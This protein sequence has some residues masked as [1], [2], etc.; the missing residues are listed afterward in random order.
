MPASVAS[1][2]AQ[3]CELPQAWRGQ[4][5][6]RI[7]DT[8]FVQGLDFF[9]TWQSWQ[10]DPQ[11][12]PMLHYVAFSRV[13][14]ALDSLQRTSQDHPALKPLVDELAPQWFGLLPGF[15]RLT[16]DSGRVLLTLCVGDTT[17]LLRQQHFQADAIF[18]RPKANAPAD[19]DLWAIKALARLCRRGTALAVAQGDSVLQAHLTQCGFEI[20]DTPPDTAESP[21]R[22]TFNP[23]WTLKTSRQTIPQAS[24]AGSCIVIGSGLAGASVAA[25]L[26]R[27]GWQVQVLDQAAT[28]AAGASGLPVGLVVPHVSTDDCTLSRLSRSGVRLMRQQA[29]SLLTEGADWQACGTLE[30]RLDGTSGLP[31]H[32]PPE[33]EDWSRAVTPA[34][35]GTL[36]AAAVDLSRDR[37]VASV[38]H[39]QAAWL[40]PAQ[41]VR[42]WLALPGIHFHGHAH[43]ATLR[44]VEG[45]WAVL[46]ANGQELARAQRVVMAN[47]ADARPL[48]ARSQADTPDLRLDADQLPVMHGV[49]GLLSWALQP[50]AQDAHFPAMPVNGAGS[51]IPGIP[52]DNG[53]AWFIGSSYQPETSPVWPDAKNHAANF[54]RLEKL[55]PPLAQV[56]APQFANGPL[57]TFKQTRCV[58]ADR[59]PVVGPMPSSPAPG[60]WLCVGMGSRGLTFSVLCAELLAAYWGAEPLPMEFSLAQSLGA[61]RSAQTATTPAL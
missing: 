46:D 55:L 31:A 23:R 61:G 26:A 39:A 9:L 7:L 42:A 50:P 29:Q 38:W 3:A 24:T 59:L 53:P 8:N 58:T 33:G 41:L 18:L 47:A 16:L 48:L 43:A 57:Q 60:L 36:P 32:W 34:T 52:T 10:N 12:S 5:A 54:G 11:R 1:E 19:W 27:R 40:K 28:P 17:T 51:V 2:F 22:A 44:P 37:G 45:G 14:P 56:L 4:A 6:W 25:S 15:H 49:R 13:A 35:V 30:Y 21:Q 20:A